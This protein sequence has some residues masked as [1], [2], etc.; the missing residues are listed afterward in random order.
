MRTT[1]LFCNI[2]GA[3]VGVLPPDSAEGLDFSVKHLQWHEKI[4]GVRRAIREVDDTL[5]EIGAENVQGTCRIGAC[6]WPAAERIVRNAREEL[7]GLLDG[8]G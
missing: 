7:E 6:H 1:H 5:S 2:C 3:I 8:W 4:E